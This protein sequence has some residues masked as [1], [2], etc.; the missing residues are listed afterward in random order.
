MERDPD[1]NKYSLFAN[2]RL[3]PQLTA[4]KGICKGRE[5]RPKGEH[6]ADV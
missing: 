3:A 1:G 4:L 5:Q 2:E 6:C